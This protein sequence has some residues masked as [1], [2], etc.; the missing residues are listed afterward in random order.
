MDGDRR[1]GRAAAL[2][3][4]VVGVAACSGPPVAGPPSEFRERT[5]ERIE[6]DGE[7]VDPVYLDISLDETGRPYDVPKSSWTP[8]EVR[9][10]P[11]TTLAPVDGRVRTSSGETVGI[12]NEPGD[13]SVE[14]EGATALDVSQIRAGG[15]GD[16]PMDR[17]LGIR[18]EVPGSDVV[19]WRSFEYA[20]GTDGGLGAVMTEAGHDRFERVDGDAVMS[21]L[22]GADAV[23]IGPGGGKADDIVVFANG[24]GDGGFPMSQGVDAEGRTVALIIWDPSFPWRLAVPDGTPPPDVTAM[25][26]QFQECLDGER[27][28]ISSS[29]ETLTG[30]EAGE[31]VC[32]TDEE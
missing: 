23:A 2:A 31:A 30:I 25:E 14:F 20:Y 15:G 21:D 27:D 10:E 4:L 29:Y 1:I 32:A 16:D 13:P 22:D 24:Y 17:I 8:G 9:V 11:V 18:I 19:R 3:A 26:D 28:L 12:S 7:P 6:A 5:E